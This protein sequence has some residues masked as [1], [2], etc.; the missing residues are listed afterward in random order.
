MTADRTE[1]PALP[2]AEARSYSCRSP[3]PWGAAGRLFP[4]RSRSRCSDALPAGLCGLLLA[5]WL[6][7]APTS[8]PGAGEP[9]G[10]AGLFAPGRLTV[11]GF[12]GGGFSLQPETRS[13]TLFALFPRVGYVLAEQAHVL[14]GSLEVAAEPGYVAVWQSQAAS[15]FSLS[16]FLKYNVFTG[17]RLTPFA[18][19]GAGVSE[20]TRAMPEQGGSHFNFVLQPG[21]GLQ[22]AVG[23]RNTLDLE[24]RYIHL[25][26]ATLFPSDPSLNGSLFLLGFSHHF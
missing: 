15:V 3:E 16:V 21:L 8:S 18:E 25:S 20:A 17:T 2:E 7:L 19:F 10:N 22:Y 26:N 4:R 1:P 23:D 5:L 14:P 24:W 13:A 9:A 6:V 11:G 12:V